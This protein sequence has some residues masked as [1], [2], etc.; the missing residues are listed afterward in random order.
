MAKKLYT[1]VDQPGIYCFKCP[2]CDFLHQI[3][4]KTYQG[5]GPKWDF[6]GDLKKPTFHPSYLIWHPG[7]KD[8]KPTG[9][10]TNVCH[11]FI[12]EGKIEFLSD[13]HH[14][15]AGKTVDLPDIEE[16]A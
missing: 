11:S 2:G 3:A 15:L 12:K 5:N 1:V 9:T 8:G 10:K 16:K 6:N 13:C 4:D 14:H 7:M